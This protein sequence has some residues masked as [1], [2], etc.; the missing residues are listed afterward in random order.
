[1]IITGRRIILA[2]LMYF[3]LNMCR[4]ATILFLVGQLN[5]DSISEPCSEFMFVAIHDDHI[6]T[7]AVCMEHMPMSMSITNF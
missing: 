2:F 3:L 6:S 5:M 7:L 1:M 4:S